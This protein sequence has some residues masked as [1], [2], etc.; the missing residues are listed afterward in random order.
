[1]KCGRSR[2]P[3]IC[4]VEVLARAAYVVT[5]E[6][7]VRAIALAASADFNVNVTR[8]EPVVWLDL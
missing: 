6:V 2:P 4:R 7:F 1:M 8:F 5:D 3:D